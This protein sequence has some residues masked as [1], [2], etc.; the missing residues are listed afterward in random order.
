MQGT[1]A[2]LDFM[3]ADAGTPCVF[4]RGGTTLATTNG[5][6][7]LKQLLGQGQ[8][9]LV[10]IGRDI[11]LIVRSGTYGSARLDDTVTIS[12]VAYLVRDLG[13]PHADGSRT[14]TL[15]GP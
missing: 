7:D 3:L 9:G 13:D 6:L 5:I 11:T 2:E 8:D 10:P 4:S 1:T 12:G 15:Q 14:L